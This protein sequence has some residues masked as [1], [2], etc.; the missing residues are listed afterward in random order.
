MS[1]TYPSPDKIV[2]N[3][4]A[5]APGAAGVPTEAI[6][7]RTPMINILASPNS[8]P[9]VLAT[10]TAA[11]TCII[12]VPFILVV[13]PSGSTNEAISSFTPSSSTVVFL[14][15]GSVAA[16]DE[17]EKP[18][19]ATLDAFLTNGIGFNLVDTTINIAYPNTKNKSKVI[20]VDTTYIKAV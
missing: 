2:N 3:T 8:Y 6:R 12:A 4:I 7:A 5:P 11:I 1:F 18:N 20:V 13:I 10:N 14:L 15:S 19:R 16:E 17:V 9:A